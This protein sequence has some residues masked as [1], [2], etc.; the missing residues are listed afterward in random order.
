M[1]TSAPKDSQDEV[2]T[3]SPGFPEL[4]LQGNSCGE[5]KVKCK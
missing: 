5:E 4:L 3:S 1:L 2:A